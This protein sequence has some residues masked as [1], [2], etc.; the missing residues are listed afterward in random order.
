MRSISHLWAKAPERLIAGADPYP[1]T[2]HLLDT[3]AVTAALWDGWLSP[4]LRRLLARE[5]ADG[6]EAL[7]RRWGCLVTALHDVGKATPVF[8]MQVGSTR[9]GV[10]SWQPAMAQRLAQE[11]LPECSPLNVRSLKGDS[12]RLARRHEYLGLVA[13]TDH[14]AASLAAL[15]LSK[16]WLPA[17]VGGHH[18]CWHLPG[19]DSSAPD[20]ATD[21]CQGPWG[22]AQRDVT[23]TVC[24]AAQLDLADTPRL[25][26]DRAGVVVTLLTGLTILADW[27]ASSDD[28]VRSGYELIAGGLDPHSPD[29][30]SSRAAALA[31][32]VRGVIGSYVTPAD[33]RAAALGATPNGTPWTPR[34]LQADAEQVRSGGTWFVAYPTGEGKTESALLRHM[35]GEPEGLIFGLPT[36]ATTDEMQV[37]LSRKFERSGNSVVLSHQY[38]AAHRVECSSEYGLAWYSSSIRRLVAPVVAATCDQVLIGALRHKHAAL[39]LLALANHHV[40]L[41]EVHTYDHYQAHLLKGL[42][43][44]WGATETRVTLLSAT[45]PAWQQRDFAYAYRRGSGPD[46]PAP[47]YPAHWVVEAH[48]SLGDRRAPSLASIQQDLAVDLVFSHAPATAHVRWAIAQHDTHPGCH[49]AVIRSTVN[50]AIDTARALT[51]ALDGSGIDVVCLHSRMTVGHRS[52]VQSALAAR[53]GPD[54][55]PSRPVL[56]V[57]TQVIEAALDYDFDLMSSDIAP[58]ASLIQR[59]GRLWRFHDASDRATR[60][61][62]LPSARVMYVVAGTKYG[63][64]EH[65]TVLPYF[66]SEMRRVAD[67]L[68][69]TPTIR[70]PQ[71]VQRFV[72]DTALDLDTVTAGGAADTEIARAALMIGAAGNGVVD[73]GRRLVKPG[74]RSGYKD[75]HFLTDETGLSAGLQDEERMGTRFIDQVSG[76][77]FILGGDHGLPDTVEALATAASA[78]VMPRALQAIVPV[79]GALNMDMDRAHR[80]T[81]ARI[82]AWSPATKTLAQALPVHVSELAAA[83]LAY[84]DSFGLTQLVAQGPQ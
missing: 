26:R 45:M 17:V 56:V 64:I 57:A 62:S 14:D 44:W 31:G 50:D 68:R 43:A 13:L 29:W 53:L 74:R 73:L 9:S 36:R 81:T 18:G 42:L 79:S 78:Q 47:A 23:A 7:G 52:K 76:T 59:A 39:R 3:Y 60:F 19:F 70:I 27:V 28:V 4:R 80:R 11:G 71:D 55:S 61:G 41:D 46:V 77:Y 69:S 30:A 37:R 2:A 16:E 12:G 20:L 15:D 67:W 65:G 84:D 72:D 63:S 38:A 75:L 33:S 48:G 83:G 51:E 5:L 1:L 82:G 54:A 10:E 66:A 35:A 25:A 6:D 58:A 21:M 49:I 40:V 32:V 24:A 34:P 8:Q 22:A